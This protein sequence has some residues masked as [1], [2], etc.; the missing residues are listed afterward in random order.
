MLF[1]NPQ[2][3]TIGSLVL[4]N[5]QSIAV[6]REARRLVEEWTDL[7]RYA[8]FADVP[9][10]RTRIRLLR[11]LTR[12][13]ATPLRPGDQ[14]LLRFRV[15]SG[16]SAAGVRELAA[17]VV[18][19]AVDHTLSARQG[20]VQRIEALAISPDGGADPITETDQRSET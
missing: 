7:G 15:A 19:T 6:D 5:V 10:Q 3:V 9:E 14:A 11:A 2:R 13:E 1:L 18:V 16:A 20:A 12:S 17:T 8:A 4:D